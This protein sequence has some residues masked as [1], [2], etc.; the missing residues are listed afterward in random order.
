MSNVSQL[1]RGQGIGPPPEWFSE[2]WARAWDDLVRLMHPEDRLREFRLCV[3]P[4]A[5]ILAVLRELRE[6]GISDPETEACVRGWLH[7]LRIDEAGIERLGL[8]PCAE[9]Y[10]IR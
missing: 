1:P 7:E 6:S 5:C 3:E 9:V 4:A 10:P 2:T 8:Q